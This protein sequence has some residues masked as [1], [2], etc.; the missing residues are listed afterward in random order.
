MINNS[1]CV[2]RT[3]VD[4][5]EH[6]FFIQHGLTLINNGIYMPRKKGGFMPQA[7]PSHD[8]STTG[9][10]LIQ[11]GKS[12]IFVFQGHRDCAAVRTLYDSF[13]KTQNQLNGTE[14]EFQRSYIDALEN[15]RDGRAQFVA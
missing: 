1:V 2:C 15:V 14:R 13:G 11:M 10:M 8:V 3:C 9:L 6:G 12:P 5:R 7:S 4:P